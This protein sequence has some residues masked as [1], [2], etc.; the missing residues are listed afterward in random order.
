[1]PVPVY[2]SPATPFPSG[3]ANLLE[4]REAIVAALVVGLTDLNWLLSRADIT[5]AGPDCVRGRMLE[6]LA[7]YQ[8]QRQVL[9][10]EAVGVGASVGSRIIG[11]LERGGL[12]ERRVAAD[13]RRHLFVSLTAAG[14]E[15]VTES[16]RQRSERL[17]RWIMQTSPQTQELVEHCL[18]VVDDVVNVAQAR[19]QFA[20]WLLR[21]P[22]QVPGVTPG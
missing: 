15:L 20:P 18:W 21:R 17:G 10:I 6:L 1:M 3:G 9:V 4:Q 5:G 13:D 14:R 2:D 12:I 22:P 19:A 11:R 16:R 8:T 7:R